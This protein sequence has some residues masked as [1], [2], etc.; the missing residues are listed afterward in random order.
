MKA[1]KGGERG[2]FASLQHGRHLNTGNFT[3]QIDLVGLEEHCSARGKL[4]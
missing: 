2:R 1:S 3:H 4:L